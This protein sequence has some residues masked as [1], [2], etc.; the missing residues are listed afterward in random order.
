MKKS[1][2]ATIFAVFMVFSNIP[3]KNGWSSQNTKE[4]EQEEKKSSKKRSLKIPKQKENPSNV[5]GENISQPIQKNIVNY[6]GPQWGL[7]KEEVEYLFKNSTDFV[8]I[9]EFGGCFKRLNL[10]WGAFVKSCVWE[11]K[12]RIF[13]PL[14]LGSF[15]GCL[16]QMG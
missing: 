3:Q 10:A 11:I 2:Y 5:G 8:C 1:F 12:Q 9:L 16:V 6:S 4:E 13:G 14:F 7:R 15:F